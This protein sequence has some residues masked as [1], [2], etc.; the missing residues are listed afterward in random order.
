VTARRV[1]ADACRRNLAAF[2]NHDTRNR[3]GELLCTPKYQRFIVPTPSLVQTVAVAGDR[4]P[5]L[6]ID[7]EWTDSNGDRDRFIERHAGGIV[8]THQL[9]GVGAV[10]V[11]HRDPQLIV[12]LAAIVNADDG[13]WKSFA[14]KSASRMNL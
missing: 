8:V 9:R 7:T 1:N 13:G 5:R 10:D 6:R 3:F 12:E 4:D 14:A 11:I 2:G